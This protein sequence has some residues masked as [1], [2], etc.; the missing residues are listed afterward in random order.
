MHPHSGIKSWISQ[1]RNLPCNIIIKFIYLKAKDIKLEPKQHDTP[2][3]PG[4]KVIEVLPAIPLVEKEEIWDFWCKTEQAKKYLQ[5]K[6]KVPA[7]LS[8]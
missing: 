5:K 2:L 7:A 4:K 8:S 6:K 3:K 1:K